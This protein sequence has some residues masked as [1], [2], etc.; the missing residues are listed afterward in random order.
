MIVLKKP[1]ITEKALSQYKDENKV[2]FE[3][4]LSADKISAKN[5]LEDTF[6]VTVEKVWTSTRLGKK[7]LN[8]LTRKTVKRTSD[9][10]IMTFKL[11]KGDKINIFD[12]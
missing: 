12:Q 3:V 1:I 8:R 9:K 7:R 4:T 5:S 6:N 2:T 10:K 11:K